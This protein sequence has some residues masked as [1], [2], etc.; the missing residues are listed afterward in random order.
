MVRIKKNTYPISPGVA[1]AEVGDICE[2]R[3]EKG[4]M[5]LVRLSDGKTV[6]SRDLLSPGQHDGDR[7]VIGVIAS[8][9][10]YTLDVEAYNAKVSGGGTQG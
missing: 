5:S 9:K 10:K 8:Y 7:P 6:F 4:R 2:W 1:R 3:K